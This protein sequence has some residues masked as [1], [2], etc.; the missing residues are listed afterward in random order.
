MIQ[1]IKTSRL[2]NE[3]VGMVVVYLLKIRR[4]GPKGNVA[5]SPLVPL[6]IPGNIIENFHFSKSF[7]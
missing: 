4:G 7:D 5:C 6:W 1:I 2:K 3:R